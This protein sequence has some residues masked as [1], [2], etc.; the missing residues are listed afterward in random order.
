[1]DH[2]EVSNGVLHAEDV[3][4]PVIAAEVGTPVYVYSRATLTRHARVFR[5]ALSIL[6]AVKIAF[7][8]KSNPNLAVLKVLAAEGYGADVVS[9]GEM[10]RALAAGMKPDGIVFSGV[11]KTEAEMRRGIE[12]GIGQFNLESEEE[13]LELA[14]IAASMGKVASAALR[15]NPDVDAGTH[16]KISTGK[17]ENKFGVPFDRAAAI[18]ARLADTPG[19]NMRGLALHIGSQLSKLDPLEAAFTK[20]G[21]LMRA[22]REGGHA[23]THMDLGGGVG[24]P[25]KAGEVFPQPAEYAAMVAKVTADWGVTLMFEP[26][27]VITGNTGVLMTQVVRVKEGAGHPWVVV[28]AAMNDLARPALYDAWHDFAAVEPTGETFVANIVGPICESSDTFAMARTIDKV[29]RGDLAV[30]RTAGAYGATMANTY[31]SR[32]LVPEVMVDGEKWA[33][34]ADRIDPATILAAER[35]PDF[36]K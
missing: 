11:G 14:E 10:E 18:Y 2:F 29:G 27:R 34:V 20:V 1:M 36:L 17:A 32:P 8:V 31:N 6:P 21:G 30:F 19:L 12:A 4:L 5:D 3:A 25:Y 22:I 9:G 33:V 23:V 35:V 7:A 28:D 13:G 15:V 24:V 26:G 16:G